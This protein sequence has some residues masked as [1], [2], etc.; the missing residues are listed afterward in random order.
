[1]LILIGNN[2]PTIADENKFVVE[3]AFDIKALVQVLEGMLESW[4]S[5]VHIYDCI[6]DVVDEGLVFK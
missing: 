1:M 6:H 4:D 5:E 2:Q 3:P